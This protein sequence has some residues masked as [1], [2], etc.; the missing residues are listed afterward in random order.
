MPEAKGNLALPVLARKPRDTA[1]P[2]TPDQA[3]ATR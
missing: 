3:K 1:R 2:S